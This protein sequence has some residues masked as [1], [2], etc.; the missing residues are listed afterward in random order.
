MSVSLP[1]KAQQS[2]RLERRKKK[3]SGEK[4]KSVRKLT[5]SIIVF[6][7]SLGFGPAHVKR[8]MGQKVGLHMW[9]KET[10]HST[11]TSKQVLKH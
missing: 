2:W 1:Y 6:V 11:K 9:A 10:Q 7:G 5:V 8:L 3:K 4:G